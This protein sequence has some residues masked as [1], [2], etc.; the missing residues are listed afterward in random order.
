MCAAEYSLHV[1]NG[2]THRGQLAVLLCIGVAAL[3]TACGG[4]SSSSTTSTGGGAAGSTTTPTTTSSGGGSGL[5]DAAFCDAARKWKG[6][7][8]KQISAL[9]NLGSGATYLKAF[10]TTLGKDY[11]AIIAVAPS[12]IKPS[13]E[14]L[15]GDFQKVNQILAGANYDIVKAG[16]KLE[17][18]KNL[19]SSPATKAA[20]AKLD[21]WAK[22]NTCKL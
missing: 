8:D 3:A 4:S 14:V 12:D 15:Y 5:S 17:K 19:F 22:A 21:A 6:Q 11:A 13:M 2:T 9:A 1:A 18:Q 7:Y 20:V 16:P 10:Y